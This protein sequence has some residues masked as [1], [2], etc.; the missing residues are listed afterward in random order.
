MVDRQFNF[1]VLCVFYSISGVGKVRPAGQ[2]RPARSV[3]PAC[4][5][6]SVVTLW[7]ARVVTCG[8]DHGLAF[9][10]RAQNIQWPRVSEQGTVIWYA[11]PAT[12]ISS[13]EPPHQQQHDS[14]DSTKWQVDHPTSSFTSGPR[15]A[16][17]R[18]I[19]P[20]IIKSLPTPALI[21]F[22]KFSVSLLAFWL[23]FLNKPELSWVE[24]NTTCQ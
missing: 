14:W 18:P 24:V 20:S 1:F 7:P 2:I 9:H 8:V 19:R 16:C 12:A 10:T 5:S 4:G 3:N 11:T 6:P 23:Q 21:K 13:L 22:M 15:Q 17:W